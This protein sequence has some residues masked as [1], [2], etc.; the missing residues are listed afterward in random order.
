MRMSR[1]ADDARITWSSVYREHLTDSSSILSLYSYS[2]KLYR[3]LSMNRFNSHGEATHPFL[4]PLRMSNRFIHN[5]FDNDFGV[6]FAND[7]EEVYR[8]VTC[9][10]LPRA[11]RFVGGRMIALHQSLVLLWVLQRDDGGSG[12]PSS[13]STC[14][15]YEPSVS[16]HAGQPAGAA[17]GAASSPLPGTPRSPRN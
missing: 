2:F 14:L 1:H 6:Q 8:P 5:S 16:Q 17:R 3:Q 13:T 7:P 15:A 12:R 9:A 11:F 4:T 10:N